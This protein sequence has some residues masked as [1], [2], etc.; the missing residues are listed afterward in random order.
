MALL[1]VRQSPFCVL[2]EV[3]AALDDAN[4]ARFCRQLHKLAD[5]SQIL[6]ITHNAITVESAAAI[7][8][9]TMHEDG[10]SDLLSLSLNGAAANGVD[11]HRAANGHQAANGRA[12]SVKA[13]SLT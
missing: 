3:D 10:V 5:R 1:H 9:V 2:D 4:V 7:Y 13:P 11:G 8:G 6:V 12:A